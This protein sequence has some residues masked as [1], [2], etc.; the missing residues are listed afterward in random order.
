M[1]KCCSAELKSDVLVVGHHG[2][3]T[4]SRNA[5]VLKSG[6]RVFLVSSGPT[7]YDEVTLPDP[8]VT[9]ASAVSALGF[10]SSRS[11]PPTPDEPAARKV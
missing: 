8:E 10:A 4:S 11:G 3:K 5:F 2:S 1:L 7:K 9:I 6:A